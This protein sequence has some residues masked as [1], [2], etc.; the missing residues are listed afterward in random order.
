M[1]EFTEQAVIDFHTYPPIGEE[2]W[3]Y[4]FQSALVRSLE[5]QMLSRAALLDMA[6]AGSFEQAA[7]L[8]SGTEYALPGGGK[9]FADVENVLLQR[10]VALRQ[11]FSELML[12][13]SV[14]ELFKARCDFANI[15]LAVKR[16][17]TEKS[18]GADYCSDGNVSPELFEQIFAEDSKFDQSVFPGYFRNA[19]EQ[20]ILSYYQDKD[21]RQV[22]YAIDRIQSQYNL[23]KALELN[24]T[25][26][27]S[28]FRVQID[29]TNIRT[30]LRLKFTESERRNVFLEGG[31]VE[32]EKL[33]NGIEH[34]YETLDTLF[35]AT[36]YH[37]IID[38]GAGYLVSEK[39]FLRVEQC[40][41]E[42][43]NGFLKSAVQITAGPQPVIA[44]LL[45][46]ENEIRTVRLILT[47]RKNH[48]DTKLILDRIS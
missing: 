7:D 48:L 19:V 32:F 22:D 8:L 45:L 41:E 13:E 36:P 31:F 38:A 16:S 21:I 24:H 33:R 20:A 25:F 18:L 37:R 2:D 11:L 6:N 42:Y 15:R 27:I 47:A 14:V 12:D 30:M 5:T 46:K 34:E 29:L 39:S 26:L 3:R 4:A 35:F 23:N 43:L 40:C 28:L 17:L 10:R 1:P 44:Y 9:D